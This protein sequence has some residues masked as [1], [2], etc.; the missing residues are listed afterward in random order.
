[1][2]AHTHTHTHAET[3]YNPRWGPVAGMVGM[4]RYVN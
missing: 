4:Q 1:M 2:R 3:G